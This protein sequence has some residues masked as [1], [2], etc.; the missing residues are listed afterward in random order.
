MVI[1]WSF[2]LVVMLLLP[3]A[4]IATPSTAYAVPS[5][6][7]L[8]T[9]AT[10]LKGYPVFVDRKASP[11]ITP[12]EAKKIA[13]AIQEVRKPIYVALI[14][15]DQATG[16]SAGDLLKGIYDGMRIDTE[17][18]IT[19]STADAMYTGAFGMSGNMTLHLPGTTTT[20]K[21]LSAVLTDWVNG[22]TATWPTPQIKG[23]AAVTPATVAEP[24]WSDPWNDTGALTTMLIVLIL[25]GVGAGIFL[26]ILL[27]RRFSRRGRLTHRMECQGQELTVLDYQRTKVFG[28]TKGSELLVLYGNA[29][30]ERNK[31]RKA[32]KKNDLAAA[33]RHLDEV[34]R[35][36]TE[37]RTSLAALSAEATA[38][39]AQPSDSGDTGTPRS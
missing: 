12:V 38:G 39:P 2:A 23:S 10:Y 26:F 17:A 34:D 1:R 22:V 7:Y 35:A 32:L 18:V 24:G 25:A 14:D 3:V 16:A 20:S 30:S 36:L 15:N 27:R 8:T 5:N 4:I 6:S 33:G 11:S 9:V 13:T 19:V 29:L 21:S 37:L 28:K 31:A